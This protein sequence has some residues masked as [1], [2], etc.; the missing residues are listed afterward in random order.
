MYTKYARYDLFVP[1]NPFCFSLSTYTQHSVNIC[2]VNV[3]I[4]IWQNVELTRGE[5][6]DIPSHFLISS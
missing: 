3:P 5:N 2:L 1:F 6:S 4:L